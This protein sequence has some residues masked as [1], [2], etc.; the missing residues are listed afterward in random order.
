MRSWCELRAPEKLLPKYKQT[1]SR[2]SHFFRFPCNF[3]GLCAAL[4][5]SLGSKSRKDEDT[6]SHPNR[7]R[8]YAIHKDT[9]RESPHFFAIILESVYS[10][11]H[12]EG[13]FLVSLENQDD[14]VLINKNRGDRTD[15]TSCTHP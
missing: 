13:L 1:N 14:L 5:F 12:S 7:S 8:M 4:S 11:G 3:Q 9:S 6:S 2:K 10:D 15:M